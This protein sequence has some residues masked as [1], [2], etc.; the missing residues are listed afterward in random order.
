M[1]AMPYAR[2]LTAATLAVLLLPWSVAA[3]GTVDDYR[4]AMG[5]R[6]R[7]DGLAVN[8]T[9]TPRF[10]QDTNR[11]HYRR[12]LQGGH[13]FVL[14]DPDAATKQPAFDHA[15]LAATLSK[16]AKEEYT[17][18][19]L[20]FN[21]FTFVDGE[22]AITFNIGQAPWRC[23]LE[24]YT[25]RPDER[26]GGGRGGG[27]G[28]LAGPVRREFDINGAEPVKSPDGNWEALVRNFNLAIRE[29]GGRDVTLL[30]TDGSEG[31]YYDP[32]SITWSPDSTKIAA[33]KVRPGH[34][35][36]VHYV[37]SSPEDQLQPK[38]TTLQYAKPG[39]VLDVELPVLFDVPAKTRTAVDT[40]LFP[41]AYTQ[42]RLQWR[43]D[44]SAF[45]FDYNE[46][47]HQVFRIVEVN[48]STGQARAVVSEKA[49]TFFNYSGK[50]FRHDVDDGREV[51]WMSERDGWNHL[52]LYDGTTGRVKNQ[53]TRG[54]WP[55]R[56][57]VKVDD[58]AR[59]IWFSASGMYPGK[60]PY[61]VHYY[62]I[63]F[64]GTGLVTLTQADA[65]HNVVFSPDMKYYVNAWSRVDL[66]PSFDVRR[67]ADNSL[68]MELERADITALE[69]AGWKPPEVFTAKGRDGVTDI[70]GVIYRPT[71][72]S[73]DRTYPVI[74]NI[75]AGPQGSFV[76]K[77]FSAFHQMQA[78]AELGFIVV[79]IDGMGT[80]NRSKAFH[81]VAWRNLGDAGFPD[82][83]LWHKAV[84]AK[85]PYYD[86]TRVGIYGTSA[87]GQ[88]AMGALLFHG[89]FYKAA[90]S[91]AGC[92]DNRMD[93]IW[94]NEQWMGYPI[95]DHYSASSNVDNAHRLEGALLL[96]VGELDMNVDPASTMQVVNALIK[97][98]KNFDLLVIPGAGHT[99]GGAY[100]DHKRYDFFVKNLLGVDPPAW[101]LLEEKRTTETT[102]SR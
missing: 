34:R 26:A 87:G 81:D 33:Y 77:S 88:S 83:I 21:T 95:G 93:K 100:G 101:R 99:A 1:R 62:R 8:T 45:T 38:H 12:S 60:D 49:E 85:Y 19:K 73:P 66:A 27:R 78:T 3:Q 96:V 50:R 67:T 86:I 4:R 44:S 37:E 89:D 25:C 40:A 36:Y 11:F 52:Y 18:L 43:R 58:D 102:A 20:P 17:A 23:T 2:L 56:S 35:R 32:L 54:E 91:A 14:V 41:N 90:F 76:P 94:W 98:N 72:F 46:R 6:D 80:S 13:E 55:V 70:W 39:D 10:V 48:A 59:Q 84:A 65:N 97:A 22:K 82:R 69:A 64:D 42:S 24:D 63:N 57:V 51:I 68:V 30:S 53:I 28:G 61:F 7:Y 15:R 16:A 79:Q 29:E 5:L 9:D 74:E 71:T 47:G 92:H 75:Y 31:G